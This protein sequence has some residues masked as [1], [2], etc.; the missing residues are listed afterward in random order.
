MY[1]V[2]ADVSQRSI[3]EAHRKYVETFTTLTNGLARAEK[4]AEEAERHLE[5]ERQRAD[6]AEQR[7]DSAEQYAQNERQRA[8]TAEQRAVT[9]EA[10]LSK[11]K[12]KYGD[13]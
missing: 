4:K 13:L 7:A 5:A 9:A 1:E 12:E 2:N 3:A 11:Y 8:D 6:S 10:L